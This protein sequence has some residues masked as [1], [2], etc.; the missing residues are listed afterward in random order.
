MKKF[1][2][3]CLIAALLLLS[4]AAAGPTVY[5]S[6]GGSGDG[7]SAGAPLGTLSAAYNALGTAGGN[8]VIVDTCTL[9]SSFTE[10]AHS[11]KVTISGGT[12]S[13]PSIRYMMNGP[14]TFENMQFN[15]TSN[16]L[17]IIAQF[18]PVEFGEGITVTGF[19][20]FG[21][22]AQSLGIIGGL[23]TGYGDYN[24]TALDSADPS[25][26]IRSGKVLL[27]GFSRG[28]DRTFTGT[29]NINISGGT[30]STVY[31]GNVPDGNG[32]NTGNGGNVELNITGGSFIGN[33][34][35]NAKTSKLAGNINMRITGGDF[36]A[37]TITRFDGSV[38]AGKT[39]V[40][41][42][43]GLSDYSLLAA[44]MEGIGSII[45][46]EGEY[47]PGATVTTNEAFLYGSF[48]DSQGTTIPYRYYLPAGYE[49]SGKDYP[50]FLFMHGNGSRGSN[51]TLQLTSSGSALNSAVFASGYDCIMLAPQCPSSPAEW[52]LYNSIGQ[53]HGYP[54][55]DYYAD[56]LESGEPY[57]SKY[58]CAA[59][60]LLDAFLKT[61][62]V[63]TQRVYIGG[64]SNGAGAVWNFLTLYPEVFAAA[65]PISGSHADPDYVHAIAHRMKNV[66]IWAFQGD[67]DTTIPVEATRTIIEALRQVNANITYTEVP[68]GTHGN[69]WSIA[70]NT[71]G[72]IDWIFA[73]RNTAYK[74]T[75]GKAK[76][77]ALPA[78]AAIGWNAGSAA[79]TAVE[80]AGA[81]KVTFYVDGVAAKT[82]FTPNTAYTPDFSELGEGARTFTVRAFP[83]DNDYSIG[84]YSAQ[85]GAFSLEIEDV[86]DFD[87]SGSITVADALVLLRAAL[88]N[89]KLIGG[90]LNG[91]GRIGVADVLRLLKFI[92]AQ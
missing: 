56:F 11:G 30:I 64:A 33:V 73:Q 28:V 7:A 12:L 65:V 20:S 67:A 27:V 81:Y 83:E 88:E 68:G 32:N 49:T 80:H 42:I 70:A 77:P 85:S 21:T 8:I 4:A 38:N 60:E 34:Y 86:A 44:K 36:S 13:T 10:P 82:V 18:H 52:S 15:G 72:L 2:F 66:A 92:A 16:Y 22:I 74:N 61:Y 58:F 84:A 46:D 45:T 91:D 29:A 89:T 76:G 71:Q 24:N 48:T 50:I 75:I 37:S 54:G 39:S 53:A 90:D 5:V 55:G 1:L 59:A 17:T 62:R 23:R 14:T 35:S 19:G 79:W 69:I 41:D 6:D 63:D 9:S 78:P 31:L 57:G 40:A 87:G 47:D 43:R 26:T 25:I 51:N 3:F